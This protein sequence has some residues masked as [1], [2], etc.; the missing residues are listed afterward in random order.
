MTPWFEAVGVLCLAGTGVLLGRWFSRLPK[1]YWATGYF[2]ALTAIALYAVGS[3]KPALSI[4]PPFSWLL[5]GRTK[6][7]SIAIIS[8]L[9][10]TTPLSRR[11]TV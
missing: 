9:V 8:A 5:M 6:F 11:E 2:L 4:V 3:R 1:P 10:L 7:A